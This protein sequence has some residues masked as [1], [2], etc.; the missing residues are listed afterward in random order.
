ME[1][2]WL[3][4]FETRKCLKGAVLSSSGCGFLVPACDGFAV[5]KAMYNICNSEGE[6]RNMSLSAK[7]QAE[8]HDWPIIARKLESVFEAAPS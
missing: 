1:K 8:R 3:S 5:A 2:S 6:L 7:A 4:G